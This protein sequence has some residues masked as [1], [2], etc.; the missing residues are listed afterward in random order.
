MSS[1]PLKVPVIGIT[2]GI[3]S[4]KT[5]V[6]DRLATLGIR[7]V[8][9]DVA[10]R[11]IMEPGR[12]ALKAVVQRFGEDILQDDGSLDRAQLRRIVFADPEQRRW[13]EAL[14]HPLIAQEIQE[15]LARAEP[16]YVVFAS[17]LLTET[18]Q[19]TFC[20]QIVVVDVPEQVQLERTMRR[21]CNEAD[22]VKRIMSAQASREQR[23]KHADIVIDN[24][25]DLRQLHEQVDA[26]DRVLRQTHGGRAN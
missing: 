16:P 20:D 18:A 15:Q 22:Q 6:T 7:I 21:D 2:G 19:A 13:L 26:L 5:A 24:G 23:L 3:G 8:D 11:I 25:G 9:A 17:P 10:A 14:T 4:G 1:S 12:P